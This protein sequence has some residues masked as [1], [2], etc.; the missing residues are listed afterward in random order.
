MS[1]LDG[2]FREA[3]EQ[4]VRAAWSGSPDNFRCGFCGY[5]FKVG[6]KWRFLFTNSSKLPGVWGN[7]LVCKTCDDTNDNLIKT[8]AETYKE[9]MQ[10]KFRRFRRLHCDCKNK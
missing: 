9:F 6:D 2:K 3:T 8:L 1:M 10:E 4:D 5:K 7:S